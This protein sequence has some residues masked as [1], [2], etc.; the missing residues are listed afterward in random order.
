MCWLCFHTLNLSRPSSS[1]LE[2]GCF[3]FLFA[4]KHPSVPLFLKQH[5]PCMPDTAKLALLTWCMFWPHGEWRNHFFNVTVRETVHRTDTNEVD[6]PFSQTVQVSTQTSA[7]VSATDT[8][9]S[10]HISRLALF[11]SHSPDANCTERRNSGAD[12]NPYLCEL[13]DWQLMCL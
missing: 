11:M 13:S 12:L 8:P 10:K 1:C 4:L 7:A 2:P 9:A 3:N 5:T 6:T